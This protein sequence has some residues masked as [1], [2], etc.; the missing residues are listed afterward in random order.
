VVATG[1][2]QFPVDFVYSTTSGK[3]DTT[4]TFSVAFT[5]ANGHQIS[6]ISSVAVN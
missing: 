1:T 5:D 6:G 4:V 3:P 2:W